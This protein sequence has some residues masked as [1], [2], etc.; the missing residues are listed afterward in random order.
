MKKILLGAAAAISVAVVGFSGSADA[1]CYWSG[2][3]WD[4]AAPQAYQ[5]PYTYQSGY[6]PYYD[7]GYTRA[8]PDYYGQYPQWAPTRYP[9]PK[10]GGSGGGY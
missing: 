9:G 5:P 1:A 8:Q 4:C 6:Q 7:Y 10:A 3:N 2:Y